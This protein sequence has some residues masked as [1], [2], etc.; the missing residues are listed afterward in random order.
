MNRRTRRT[1]SQSPDRDENTSETSLLQGNATLINI[2]E[3]LNNIFDR[4]VGSELTDPSQ[5]SNETEVISERLTEQNNAKM[6]QIE[7]QLNSKF[8]EILKEISTKKTIM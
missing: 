1:E 7:E 2:S 8:E 3:N 4:N 5:I 6:T